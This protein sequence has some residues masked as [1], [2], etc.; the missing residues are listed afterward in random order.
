MLFK[1]EIKI[2]TSEPDLVVT[3]F[4][5]DFNYRTRSDLLDIIREGMGHPSKQTL[6]REHP[7][8]RMN[9]LRDSLRLALS[10]L[11]E[12]SEG[13]GFRIKESELGILPK[14]DLGIH[15][16]VTSA[17]SLD[18]AFGG[19]LSAKNVADILYSIR[20]GKTKRIQDIC[21]ETGINVNVPGKHLALLS[22]M[23]VVNFQSYKPPRYS[24]NAQVNSFNGVEERIIKSSPFDASNYRVHR[25]REIAKKLYDNRTGYF[26][27]TQVEKLIESRYSSGGINRNLT[28]G[29]LRNLQ[30]LGYVCASN[31]F[32][33]GDTQSEV[34][35]VFDDDG[36][37]PLIDLVVAVKGEAE[38]PQFEIGWEDAREAINIFAEH[39]TRRSTPELRKEQIMAFLSA[40][41]RATRK[42]ITA[43]TKCGSTFGY[44]QQL[45]DEGRI[46][47]EKVRNKHFYMPHVYKSSKMGK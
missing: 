16:V 45:K 22:E 3:K 41:G 24:W 21:N 15:T 4:G 46:S 43:A 33:V 25:A 39:Y 1:D 31:I 8:F 42:E 40:T 36:H 9:S 26:D 28:A 18:R 37:N 13:Q 34:S 44:L 6:S 32:V 2:L 35:A 12:G 17:I 27:L 11:V 14:V 19:N 47:Y 38:I 10:N 30:R 7:Y 5:L 23:G 20:D 29:A